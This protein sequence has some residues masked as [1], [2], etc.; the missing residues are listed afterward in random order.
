MIFRYRYRKS[1]DTSFCSLAEQ[2]RGRQI[3]VTIDDLPATSGSMAAD[4]IVEMTTTLL[5]ALRDEKVPVVGFVNERKLYK[6]GEVDRRI[7]ALHLWLDYGFELGNHT[8]SHASLS[9]V[10]LSAWENDVIQGETVSRLLLAE[11]N[12]KLRYF[13]AILHWRQKP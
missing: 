3:A 11:R 7:K 1:P 12:M 13:R 6:L 8:L 9:R 4:A 2:P 10:G 5:T